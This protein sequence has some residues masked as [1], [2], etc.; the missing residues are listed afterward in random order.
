MSDDSAVPPNNGSVLTIPQIIKAVISSLAE[1]DLGALF[2]NCREEI[3]ACHALE[4]MGHKQPPTPIQTDNTTALGI[5][6]NNIASKRLKSMDMKLHWIR[7]LIAQKQF[8]HYWQTGPNNL[9][10]YVTK[11]HL[12]IHHRAVRGIYLTPKSKLDLLRRRQCKDASAARVYS[13]C[14]LVLKY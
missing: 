7:C 10:N 3:P 4:T 6:T 1:A 13:T 2:I 11:H 5:V 14:Q 8:R 12:A 9:G